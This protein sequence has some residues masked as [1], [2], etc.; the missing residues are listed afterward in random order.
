VINKTR[1]PTRKTR[2]PKQPDVRYLTTN[3]SAHPVDSVNATV[4]EVITAQRF[5]KCH[6]ARQAH[7]RA[8]GQEQQAADLRTENEEQDVVG[9]RG[10]PAV[11][12]ED[13]GQAEDAE[14]RGHHAQVQLACGGRPRRPGAATA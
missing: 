13:Q 1:Q 8:R 12:L 7:A 14:R 5:P 10:T 6:A 11:T 2:N 3:A 4:S 9:R